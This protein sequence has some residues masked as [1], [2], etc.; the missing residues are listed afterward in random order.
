MDPLA[1]LQGYLLRRTIVAYS[2][3]KQ[4]TATVTPATANLP[5]YLPRKL[6]KK[7]AKRE[8]K[9]GKQAGIHQVIFV[10]VNGLVNAFGKPY[11][12]SGRLRLSFRFYYYQYKP[13]A[14]MTHEP[15]NKFE[16]IFLQP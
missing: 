8:V 5:N 10:I 1:E 12:A 14:Y 7:E 15:I 6:T 4:M 16:C 9:A 3:T 11:A 13:A 2:N